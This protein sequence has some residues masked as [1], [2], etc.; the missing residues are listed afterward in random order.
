MA[1]LSFIKAAE[2][3]VKLE[4]C[5]PVGVYSKLS[6]HSAFH[7]VLPCELLH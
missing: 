5:F 1:N 6:Q 3:E 2:T 7:A 4:A